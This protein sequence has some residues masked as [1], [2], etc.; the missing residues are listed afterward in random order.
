[1]RITQCGYDGEGA[2]LLSDLG[3]QKAIEKRE[4]SPAEQTFFCRIQAKEN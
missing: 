1:M 4:N 2:F 3:E